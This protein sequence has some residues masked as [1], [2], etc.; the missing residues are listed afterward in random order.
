MKE[1]LHMIFSVDINH[2]KTV[3]HAKEP[4][5]DVFIG[6]HLFIV[7]RMEDELTV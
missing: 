6:S 3:L 7:D 5:E 4:L 1:K 2:N